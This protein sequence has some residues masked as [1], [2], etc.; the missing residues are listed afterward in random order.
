MGNVYWQ[1]FCDQKQTIN[2]TVELGPSDKKTDRQ[3]RQDTWIQPGD[4]TTAGIVR[5]LAFTSSIPIPIPPSIATDSAELDI[6]T[7]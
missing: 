1:H 7:S 2:V 3:D 6:L 4:R 5:A